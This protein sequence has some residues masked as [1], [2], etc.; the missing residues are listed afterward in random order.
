MADAAKKTAPN[1][2]TTETIASAS[3][4]IAATSAPKSATRTIAMNGAVS[5]S[6]RARSF[7]MIFW[8]AA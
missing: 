1:V 4:S 6:A 5:V 8:K 7:S 2:M 3:G